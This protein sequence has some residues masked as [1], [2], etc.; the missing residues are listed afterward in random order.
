MALPLTVKTE[1]ALAFRH[2]DPQNTTTDPETGD[3]M[4]EAAPHMPTTNLEDPNELER[5]SI[6]I[7][8]EIPAGSRSTT[9]TLTKI[10]NATPEAL[11]ETSIEDLPSHP[12]YDTM[13]GRD[14]PRSD[15]E[16]AA[17]LHTVLVEAAIDMQE[18]EDLGGMTIGMVDTEMTLADPTPIAM[19]K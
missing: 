14:I 19:K 3:R 7:D 15:H 4:I 10:T 18:G 17:G 13:I 9:K 16:R 6:Q 11:T 1:T 12:T 2:L 8:L 5:R